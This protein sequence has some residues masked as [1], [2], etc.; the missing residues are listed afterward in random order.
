MATGVSPV[1]LITLLKDK[2]LSK[3]RQ[4]I[5]CDKI[6]HLQLQACLS[7]LARNLVPAIFTTS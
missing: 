3:I 7:R 5:Y 2:S 6:T 1:N 4:I